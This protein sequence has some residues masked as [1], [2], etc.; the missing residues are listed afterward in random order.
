MR[1]DYYF[2]LEMIFLLWSRQRGSDVV[3][4]PIS[5][6]YVGLPGKKQEEKY[7]DSLDAAK[8]RVQRNKEYSDYAKA[9]MARFFSNH[10]I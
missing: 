4:L 6:Q 5:T 7:A 3:E 8:K 10:A 2:E 9:C 1:W